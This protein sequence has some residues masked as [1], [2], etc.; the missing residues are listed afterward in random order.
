M[1]LFKA[2]QIIRVI[3]EQAAGY[4]YRNKYHICICGSEG[5]Y[6][7][8]NSRN[9]NGAFQLIHA[10]FP[11]LPNEN[12]Y[13]ACNTLLEVPDEYM[14]RNQAQLIGTLPSH[15]IVELL[16]HIN[17]CEVLTDN[18][19]EIAVSGLSEAL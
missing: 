18:E 2:G 8:I 12:S 13:I 9:W 17:E 4:R 14:D 3:S 19:I 5:R 1:S 16:D 6:F 11:E 10:D 7:F 15:I